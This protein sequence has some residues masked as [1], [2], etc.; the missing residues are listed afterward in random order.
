MEAEFKIGDEVTLDR[1]NHIDDVQKVKVVGY[2]KMLS[3]R[4]TYKMCV[5]GLIIESTGGS[6]MESKF[7][8]PVPNEQR[9]YRKNASVVEKEEY[10][11]R[12]RQIKL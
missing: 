1:Y 5:S 10:W 7:Y 12:V 2:G 6:I 8:S 11:D 3:G 9:H 4:L